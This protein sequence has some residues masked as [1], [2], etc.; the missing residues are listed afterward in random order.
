MGP[1]SVAGAWDPSTMNDWWGSLPN[2]PVAR[3]PQFRLRFPFPFHPLT[4]Q[5]KNPV[6]IQCIEAAKENEPDPFASVR[7]GQTRPDPWSRTGSV[8]QLVDRIDSWVAIE[9]ADVLLSDWFS[10][11]AIALSHMGSGSYSGTISLWFSTVL[12]VLSRFFSLLLF[13]RELS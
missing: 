10:T 2:C 6:R 9:L 3:A 4:S 11:A 13:C 7:P 8:W 1:Q 12:M 5:P